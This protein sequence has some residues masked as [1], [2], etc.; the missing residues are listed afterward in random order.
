MTDAVSW[1]E[2]VH[3]I[4]RNTCIEIFEVRT[5][6]ILAKYLDKPYGQCGWQ[7]VR[8]CPLSIEYMNYYETKVSNVRKFVCEVILSRTLFT[9]F[10]QHRSLN[11]LRLKSVRLNE[12]DANRGLIIY[13]TKE[14]KLSITCISLIYL[15]KGR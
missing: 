8:N 14:D 6:S 11:G 15:T 4:R 10:E 5:R 12:L 2:S 13:L 1:C 7:S 3:R 9:A